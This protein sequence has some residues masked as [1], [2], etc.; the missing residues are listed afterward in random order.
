MAVGVGFEPVAGIASSMDL[1]DSSQTGTDGSLQDDLVC[2]VGGARV[3]A[4]LRDRSLA[5]GGELEPKGLALLA[6]SSIYL[7]LDRHIQFDRQVGDA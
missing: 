4:R 1:G 5:A 3:T 6:P 7:H 2:V